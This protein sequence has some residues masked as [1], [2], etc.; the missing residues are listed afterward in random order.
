M[1]IQ[2]EL[3]IENKIK[4][5]LAEVFKDL[6]ISNKQTFDLFL[7]QKNPSD[8]IALYDFYYYTAKWQKTNQPKATTYYVM[9]G[10]KWGKDKT[11]KVKKQLVELGLIQD[12]RKVNKNSKYLGWY[13][14]INYIWGENTILDRVKG[15][16][17]E[18]KTTLLKTS[19]VVPK[20]TL[21]KKKRVDSEP[22]NALSDGNVNAL[23]VN[24]SVATATEFDFPKILDG[25]KAERRRDLQIIGLYWTYK[26]FKFENQKQYQAALKRELRASQ[27][28]V[29]YPNDDITAVMDWLCENS[30][31][32]WTLETI[33]KYID[34]D[35]SSLEPF[36]KGRVDIS[37]Y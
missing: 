10:L 14:K 6:I 2:N 16:L 35:L 13:I 29:G 1:V 24:N 8:L 15:T 9:K 31:I 32:K 19:S 30:D 17:L 22:P 3:E 4:E 20:T 25:L 37:K 23:S 21:L 11:R 27:R 7:K 12:V 36:K 33:H 34:E 5:I 18:N 26:D 28:L